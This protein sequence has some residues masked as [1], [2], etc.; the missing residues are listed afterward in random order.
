[1]VDLAT[2][3]SCGDV[4]ISKKYE[5]LVEIISVS[6]FEALKA[7]RDRLLI[8]LIQAVEFYE[9][10]YEEDSDE[11]PEWYRQAEALASRSQ[12]DGGV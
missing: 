12:K 2:K 3:E 4:Y 5:D 10:C 7:D 8:I 9:R 6:D 1:M 11:A